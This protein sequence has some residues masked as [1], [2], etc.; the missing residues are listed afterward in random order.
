MGTRAMWTTEFLYH[1]IIQFGH[2]MI[3]SI[4]ALTAFWGA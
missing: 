3:I 2:Y 4:M 1:D